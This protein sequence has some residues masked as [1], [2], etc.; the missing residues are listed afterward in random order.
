M[1]NALSAPRRRCRRREYLRGRCVCAWLER[2][3]SPGWPDAHA[4]GQGWLAVGQDGSAP[5]PPVCM[6]PQVQSNFYK[7]LAT[8]A[9]ICAQTSPATCAA[10]A[11]CVRPP[12]APGVPRL[13][14]R[15][16]DAPRHL[17]HVS[18]RPLGDLVVAATV[19]GHRADLRPPLPRAQMATPAQSEQL[20][21]ASITYGLE[22]AG[23]ATLAG[24]VRVRG[25]ALARPA[26]RRPAARRPLLAAVAPSPRRRGACFA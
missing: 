1:L 7:E 20:P 19:G 25:L 21:E 3:P 23:F 8:V 15:V 5:R 13:F 6:P 18:A 17:K 16:R 11:R 24:A 22:P 10:A 12:S 2:C 4:F 9:A 26:A 14:P